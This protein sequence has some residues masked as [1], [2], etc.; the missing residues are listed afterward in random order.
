MNRDSIPSSESGRNGITE[1]R[2]QEL[3]VLGEHAVAVQVAVGGEIRDDLEFVLRVLEGTRHAL[4]AVRAVGEQSVEH[5]GGVPGLLFE[6]AVGV[7]KQRGG[8]YLSFGGGVVLH[9]VDRW[10]DAPIPT[11]PRERG[12][13]LLLDA[14][15]DVFHSLGGGRPVP[16]VQGAAHECRYDQ[17]QLA[18]QVDRGPLAFRQLMRRHLRDQV[19]EGAAV[20]E[21][22]EVRSTRPL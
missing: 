8:D 19:L 21:Q 10:P 6:R 18:V 12:G 1:R 14:V 4:A 15:S 17:R 7:G 16:L 11:L 13:S 2:A 20:A 22:T 3:A 5:R 9:E